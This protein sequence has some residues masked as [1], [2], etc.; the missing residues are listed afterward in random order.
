[1]F[2]VYYIVYTRRIQTTFG[3][4]YSEKQSSTKKVLTVAFKHSNTIKK[5]F[6]SFEMNEK[7]NARDC[8]IEHPFGFKS[9]YPRFFWFIPMF[10]RFPDVCSKFCILLASRLTARIGSISLN[11]Y[12][13]SE[14]WL[15]NVIRFPINFVVSSDQILIKWINRWKWIVSYI[16]L[17]R[18]LGEW[19]NLSIGNSSHRSLLLPLRRW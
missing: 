15:P 19:M 18:C 8:E 1:M 6:F 10:I 2:G 3:S 12:I 14:K 16:T 13:N 9:S 5:P 7:P 4:I 11:F 17:G